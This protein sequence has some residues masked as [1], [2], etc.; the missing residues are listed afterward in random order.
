MKLYTFEINKQRRIGAEW[1]DQLIDLAA[2]YGA[3]LASQGPKAGALRVLPSEMLGFIRLG[4]LAQQAA[5]ETIQYIKKRPAVPVG[6]EL[7]YPLEQVKILAPIPRPGKILCCDWNYPAHPSSALS[8]PTPEEPLIFSKF[9]STV[10]GPGEPIIQ[11][12]FAEQLEGGVVLG[13]VIGR[14]IKSAGE[15]EARE[16]IFG[17]TVL[18][19]VSAH[20]VR[21]KERQLTLRRNLD[22]FCPVGPCIVTSEEIADASALTVRASFGGKLRQEGSTSRWLFP[23][24]RL[25]S[26]LSEGLTLEPGDIVCTGTPPALGTSASLAMPAGSEAMV[27][28]EGIGRLVN[29]VV[30]AQGT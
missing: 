25:V 12:A 29:P 17:Y 3:L 15:E 27:E 22:T 16:G 20:Q 2:T 26:Y 4:S 28:I 5:R 1:E 14:R 18:N 11:P 7:F 23:P 21:W 19:D 24:A 10:I 30:N 13:A 9:P 8:S 6:E